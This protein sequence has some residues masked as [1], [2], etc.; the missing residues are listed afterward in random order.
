MGRT[1]GPQCKQRRPLGLRSQTVLALLLST[2]TLGK[3]LQLLEPQCLPLQNGHSK[4][5]DFT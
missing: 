2:M 4:S 1:W 3:L 5:T